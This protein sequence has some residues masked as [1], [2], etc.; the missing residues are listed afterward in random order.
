MSSKPRRIGS[1]VG[2]KW[3]CSWGGLAVKAGTYTWNLKTQRQHQRTLRSFL[4]TSN[5]HERSLASINNS[6][7]LLAMTTKPQ[8]YSQF[9]VTSGC[10]RYGDL[11]NVWHGASS[12]SRE[13]PTTIDRHAGEQLLLK[14]LNSISSRR[15]EHGT[16]SNLSRKARIASA[17][18]S[19]LIP[20]STQR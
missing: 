10:L 18:G 3:S 17:H 20:M 1:S 14:S 9:T 19:R 5:L 6:D 16:L 13:F 8:V 15:M 7:T 2:V 11:H 4:N 12:L